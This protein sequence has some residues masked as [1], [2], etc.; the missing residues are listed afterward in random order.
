VS[1]QEPNHKLGHKIG[2]FGANC[3][4]IEKLQLAV[5]NNFPKKPICRL[6]STSERFLNSSLN[7]SAHAIVL[8]MHETQSH[9]ESLQSLLDLTLRRSTE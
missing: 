5:S 1:L 2:V 4:S 8:E 6:A 7:E 3:V 9:Q